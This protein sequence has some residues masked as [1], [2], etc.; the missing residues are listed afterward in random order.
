MGKFKDIIDVALGSKI[1]TTNLA[2]GNT[3]AKKGTSYASTIAPKTI[4]QTRQDIKNWMLAKNMFLSAENPKRYPYYNLVDNIMVDLHLQSQINNRML[5]S[6]SKPFIMKDLKG[7]LDQELTDLLQNKRF[8]YQVNKAIL[9]TIYYGHSLGEFDYVN[10]DLVFNLVPR[11]NVEPV[12]GY[13]IY[14]YLDEK[15]I[16]Y[17][18]QKEY[19]SWLIEFG[20]NK[21]F[22]LLDGC[23]PHVLFKRFAQSC[24][25]ELCEIYGIPP[26]VLKTNT[27]DRTMVSRGERMMKDMGAAA[28][29]IIDENESF[30]FAQGVSTNGDVYKG[31]MTFCNNEM[32]MG[33][34]GT[35]V[36]QDTKN[37]S[38]S[39]EKTSI[40]IL[41]DLIDSDLSLIEQAWNSTV[42]P[43]L[44][45]LGIITKDV[46]YTY[47]PAE[48]LDKLWKMTTEAAA[49]LEIDSNWVKDTFG[50][51]VIGAKQLN[52]TP[53]A[54]LS[55]EDYE[56]FFV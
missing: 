56:R 39:K 53:P 35:V 15:K 14:D 6:L 30:E 51:E 3:T 46:I 1:A 38:N 27:Q 26:R 50:I 17:R 31:I 11:Q 7:N 10:G 37:G 55:L 16:E 28:W 24:Y 19:G 48:D 36:G 12:N 40:S 2:A 49:F 20:A 42:I 13:L 41:Q 23:I 5:K 25:S 52:P 18:Q 43:A 22:G 45:A 21:D 29:F 44:K 32:S 33:I 54:K 47:P 4:S 8:V 9:Q 34:A